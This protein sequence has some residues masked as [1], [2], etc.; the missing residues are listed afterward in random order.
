[1]QETKKIINLVT[2]S[3]PDLK[4]PVVPPSS[5]IGIGIG[6]QGSA[7]SKSPRLQL[8]SRNGAKMGFIKKTDQIV[9]L[10]VYVG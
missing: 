7:L 3:L 4:P 9:I 2:I 10:F 1:M 6:I 8:N 5:L